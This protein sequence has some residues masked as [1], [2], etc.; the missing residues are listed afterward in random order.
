MLALRLD[1]P[2]RAVFVMAAVPPC[3]SPTRAAASAASVASRPCGGVTFRGD[4]GSVFE[5]D[6]INFSSFGAH[7]SPRTTHFAG[8][9]SVRSADA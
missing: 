2:H 3:A 8:P 5:N 7:P 9:R 4:A 1:R 6:V